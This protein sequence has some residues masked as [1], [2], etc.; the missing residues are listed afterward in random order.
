MCAPPSKGDRWLAILW[1][2]QELVIGQDAAVDRMSHAI[3]RARSGLADPS[4]PVA[5]LLFQ[6]PTGV[7]KTEL[8]RALAST[9]FGSDTA[10]V[11]RVLLPYPLKPSA[12][13]GPRFRGLKREHM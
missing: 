7:G 5:S 3:T 11:S 1:D 13:V 4:R 9:Y 6:G 8:A 12:N 2:V 10:L